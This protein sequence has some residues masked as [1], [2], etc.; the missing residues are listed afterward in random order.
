[1]EGNDLL[2]YLRWPDELIELILESEEKNK[3]SESISS[4]N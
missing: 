3:L 2:M 4:I 1:M